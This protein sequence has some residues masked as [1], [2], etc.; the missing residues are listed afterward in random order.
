MM[1]KKHHG[2]RFL[3]RGPRFSAGCG[4]GL[5]WC[6]HYGKAAHQVSYRRGDKR[7]RKEAER[8]MNI[9]AVWNVAH[10]GPGAEENVERIF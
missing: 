2:P 1:K 4:L 10:S 9:F 7:E 3:Y 5:Y 6:D 8:Q